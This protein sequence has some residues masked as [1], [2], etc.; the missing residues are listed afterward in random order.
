MT[1]VTASPLLNTGYQLNQTTVSEG[2]SED[3]VGL[4]DTSCTDI[5]HGKDERGGC[6]TEQTQGCRVG[7]LSVV[8]WEGGLTGVDGVT[9]GRD[10]WDKGS[11]AS[12]I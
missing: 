10:L 2:H 12:S 7:E 8:N 3:N 9:T 4:A 6:E 11:L 1:H 5:V